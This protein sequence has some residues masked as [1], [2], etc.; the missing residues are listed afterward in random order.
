M[1]LKILAALLATVVGVKF[2]VV[3]QA[4]TILATSRQP[5]AGI[6]GA[7]AFG[8][9]FACLGAVL[10]IDNESA[11]KFNAALIV[12]FAII[13]AALMIFAARSPKP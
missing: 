6:A 2:F 9:M 13:G 1:A 7:L 8:L 11:R 10:V 5:K 4:R 12:V 3:P